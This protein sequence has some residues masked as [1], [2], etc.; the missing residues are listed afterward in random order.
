[1]DELMSKFSTVIWD[2]DGTLADSVEDIAAAANRVLEAAGLEPLP[3]SHVRKMIGEGAGKLLD[4]AFAARGISEYDRESAYD[5]FLRHYRENSCSHTALYPGVASVLDTFR[6]EGLVQGICTNKPHQISVDILQ[7][8]GIE[9]YFGAVVGGDS[10]AKR[11]PHP[12]PLSSCIEQL[13]A[14][15]GAV[16]MV[17][18][19]VTDVGAAKA[20]GVAVAVVSWGYSRQPPSD[21]GADFL[22]QQSDDLLRFVLSE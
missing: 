14:D 20:C 3:S 6:K 18:D 19:S 2:L 17:G 4:R 1:M 7:Q 10:T 9:T 15:T 21:L 8:L 13:G 16:L 11:K 22:V 12:L 5:L